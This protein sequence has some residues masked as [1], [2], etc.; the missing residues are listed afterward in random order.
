MRDATRRLRQLVRLARQ[1]RHGIA[2]TLNDAVYWDR[3]ARN[4]EEAQENARYRLLGE[5]W[6]N[7]ERFVS[8]LERHAANAETALEIGCGGGKVTAEAARLFRHLDA[9]DVSNEMLRKAREGVTEPNVSFHKLDGFTL[10][11]FPDGSLD[12]V[13]SHDVFV[14]FSSLQVYPYLRE[15]ARVLNPGGVA[16]IS[17]YDLRRH[18]DLFREMSLGF[19]ARRRFPPHMRVHFVTEEMVRLF[20]DEAGLPVVEADTENFLIAVLRKPPS[21]DSSR[22]G[23][24]L[25]ALS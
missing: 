10:E 6:K 13:Y 17:F 4:W 9:G 12:C 25:A 11:G 18:F 7:H 16:L 5:E 19:W 21:T 23:A 14:H 8:L 3:Y 22:E 24:A 20:A 2:Y 15:I 1:V